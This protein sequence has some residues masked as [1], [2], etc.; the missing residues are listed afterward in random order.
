M[1]LYSS[2]LWLFF[3][4]KEWK[5]Y[6]FFLRYYGACA[7]C[8]TG[9]CSSL[10]LRLSLKPLLLP[11]AGDC[12]VPRLYIVQE[13]RNTRSVYMLCALLW[14]PHLGLCALTGNILSFLIR[15]CAC[16]SRSLGQSSVGRTFLRQSSMS[17]VEWESSGLTMGNGSPLVDPWSICSP[18]HKKE[19]N[20]ISDFVIENTR[21]TEGS[22]HVLHETSPTS[23]GFRLISDS[24]T[25]VHISRRI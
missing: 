5:K 19:K 2:S 11:R 8:T 23:P 9:C 12:C 1:K 10:P 25:R 13:Q 6:F 24:H 17:R 18:T 22:G 4:S 20:G 14:A 15:L 16:V 21:T 3:L 7:L